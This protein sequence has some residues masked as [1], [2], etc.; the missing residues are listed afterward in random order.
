LAGAVVT[1]TIFSWPGMGLLFIEHVSR[2][3]A[4]VVMG[5]LMLISVAV[6]L[7][8]LLTDVTYAW[9]DPRIR[10]E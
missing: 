10:Y 2:G 9:L 4:P 3:D 8:Q 6:V 5:I 7:A 1:E